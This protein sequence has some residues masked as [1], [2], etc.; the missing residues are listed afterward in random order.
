MPDTLFIHLLN[1]VRIQVVVEDPQGAED[2]ERVWGILQRTSG[3]SY[4][5]FGLL[6]PDTLWFADDGTGADIIP[7]DGVFSQW[8]KDTLFE[9]GAGVYQ[10][11]VK[12]RDREGHESP[13]EV[14][15]FTVLPQGQNAPPIIEAVWAPD[16]IWV[17]R[18]SLIF[19]AAYAIDPDSPDGVLEVLFE[20][21]P[22]MYPRPFYQDTLWDAG[23]QGD[24]VAGD[25]WFSKQ[26]EVR[27]LART[28]GD[29]FF[30]FQA[31]DQL[32]GRSDPVVRKV[33]LQT[34]E[35]NEPPV[36]SNLVAPDTI[37]RSAGGTYLI[38]VDVYDPQGREDID[39]VYFNSFKPD[40][41]PAEG[42][43]FLMRDD[44]QQGDAQAGDGTYSIVITISPQNETGRY[45]FEFQAEDKSGARSNL[46]IHFITVIP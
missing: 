25:Y 45:R 36:L 28:S 15:S 17:E 29:Y 30:R 6:V 44:G 34:L 19:V 41:S 9:A 37:S 2:I 38:T 12:A 20:V 16:S 42:N 24:S 32:G 22:P 13:P 27:R 10:L 8:L 5:P 18:D 31:L 3:S 21:Y 40:G 14:K 46:L 26:V 43:P 1:P 23:T 4:G 35:V 33:G 11:E 7:K 39:R